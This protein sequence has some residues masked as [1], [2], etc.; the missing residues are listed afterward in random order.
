MLGTVVHSFAQPG[1]YRA[2]VHE[3]PEVKA[4]FT[5]RSDNS[6]SNAQTSIDLATLVSGPD[7]SHP[8]GCT[9]CGGPSNDAGQ[10]TFVVNPR[11][12]VLF[13]VSRGSGGYYVHARRTD[14]EEKDKGYD[15]RTLAPGDVFTAIVLRPGT[16]AIYNSLTR[17]KGELVVTYP[18]RGE[19][20]YRPPAPVRVV[21][22]ERNF[23]PAQIQVGPGQGVIFESRSESRI[24]IKLEKPDDGP[25]A[26]EPSRRPGL[27]TNR[28]R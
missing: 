24:Q 2:V 1:E 14:A 25:E 18:V 26:K 20:R 4:V 22:G 9:C 17:A 27:L 5:I 13:H 6:S 3:G 7:A 11:G 8:D 23:E 10:R 21:C 28:L 15:S 12:Y 16:Y 19:K